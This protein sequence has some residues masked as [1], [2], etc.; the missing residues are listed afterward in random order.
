MTTRNI[1]DY[2]PI[3]TI[4]GKHLVINSITGEKFVSDTP[5]EA[6]ALAGS[7][8][9][10]QAVINAQQKQVDALQKEVEVSGNG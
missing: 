8:E 1:N 9:E 5:E 2:T 10:D 3:S 6:V 4:D 7:I